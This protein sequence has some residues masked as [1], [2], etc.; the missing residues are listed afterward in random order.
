MSFE[1]ERTEL[2]WPGKYDD[3]GKRVE[4]ERVN[5]PFQVIERVNESRATREKQKTKDLSLFD[6]WE[7]NEGETFDEG[8]RNKLIWG[9][10]RL[11]MSSLL[12]QFSGKVDLIYIDP[13]FAIGADFVVKTLV[14]EEGLEKSQSAIEEHAYRDTWGAGIDSYI[15][16][17]VPRLQFARELLTTSGLIFVHCDWHL[18]NIIRVLLDEIFGRKRFVNEIIWHY[19]NKY[20][21][22]KSNVPRAHD[23]IFLYSNG[24]DFTLNELREERTEPVKQLVRENVGGVLRNKRDSHGNLVYQ[25]SYDKKVDDVWRIPALQPASHEWTGYPTQKHPALVER[26]LELASK[27][28]DLVA[29]FFVGSGTTAVV[30]ER[31][32]RRWIGADLGRFAVHTTRKRLQEIDGCRPFEVLNLGRYERSYWNVATFGEDLDGDGTVNLFEYLAFILRLYG[33]TPTTGMEHV[34]GEKEGALIHVG[35][36]DAPVTIDEV[37]QT[38]HECVRL[39]AK[40]LHVLGWEW[41]MGLHDLVADEAKKRG[42]KLVL[43]QIPNEAM[44]LEDTA[45]EGA[46]RFFELAALDVE[47]EHDDSSGAVSVHLRNFAIPNPELV[48]ADV[49]EAVETW[50]DYVDY[51]AVDWSYSDDSFH[52]GWVTYRT[53]QDRTLEL[54]SDAHTYSESG[55]YKV[56]IKVIDIFGID[57]STIVEVEV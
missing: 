35:S 19:Y 52:Q 26:V 39:R 51:W 23:V 57:T 48:P 13:P 56:M 29:D 1:I 6:T 7:G 43:R 49:R 33:A 5:L 27:P 55:T 38:V 34:H 25:T 54:T 18:G 50:S 16:M 21:A 9:D 3:D 45:K 15:Q 22:A 46:V 17:M 11:I 4:P 44:E 42:V 37:D 47:T 40:E 31:M 32:E 10:N 20:S 36:V 30:A 2:V 28:G 12:E 24:D 14:G 53:R 8:W 41:E